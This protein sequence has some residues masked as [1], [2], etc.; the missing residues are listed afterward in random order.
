MF[1]SLKIVNC[2][3]LR[4]QRSPPMFPLIGR[5]HTWY[6]FANVLSTEG[7]SCVWCICEKEW[8]CVF[9]GGDTPP[10]SDNWH[11][12]LGCTVSRQ[13]LSYHYPPYTF[14]TP[15]NMVDM[16]HCKMNLYWKWRNCNVKIYWG[17]WGVLFFCIYFFSPDPCHS[18]AYRGKAPSHTEMWCPLLPEAVAVLNEEKAQCMKKE[19]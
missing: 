18:S 6:L 11:I 10:W 7:W 2:S 3:W 1:G 14:F 19:N 9:S 12:V 15:W 8:M 5:I 13:C 16:V 17:Q 4:S